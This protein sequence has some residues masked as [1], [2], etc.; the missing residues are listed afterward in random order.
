VTPLAIYGT[1]LLFV[2]VFG[3]TP[4]GLVA[5]ATVYSIR[6]LAD[7]PPKGKNGPGR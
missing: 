2:L 5:V 7:D 6:F 3:D 4:Q 1:C